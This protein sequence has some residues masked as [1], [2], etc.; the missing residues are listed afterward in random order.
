MASTLC[1]NVLLHLD[2]VASHKFSV[3]PPASLDSTAELN[4]L[5]EGIGI[6]TSLFL[7]IDILQWKEGCENLSGI[8]ASLLDM[9]QTLFIHSAPIHW[10]I[11]A[12]SECWRATYHG[13]ESHPGE[14]ANKMLSLK[15]EHL[16]NWPAVG[17]ILPTSFDHLEGDFLGKKFSSKHFV[18][19]WEPFAL[20]L[21][22]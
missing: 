9:V 7:N 12:S 10:P 4:K 8:K 6:V 18:S 21:E 3:H 11:R 17:M 1:T 14:E 16:A 20:L 13:L 15:A 2:S 19:M 22:T 5:D